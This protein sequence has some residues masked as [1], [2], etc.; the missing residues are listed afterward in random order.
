MAFP[1]REEGKKKR[2][3]TKFTFIAKRKEREGGRSARENKISLQRGER[4]GKKRGKADF[5]WQGGKD[6]QREGRSKVSVFVTR[7]FHI[8]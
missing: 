5:F 1:F 7:R 8:N 4:G 3:Q 2:G 6:F